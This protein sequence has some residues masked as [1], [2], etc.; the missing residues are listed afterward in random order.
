M[1]PSGARYALDKHENKTFKNPLTQVKVTQRIN[2]IA[3]LLQT[4]GGT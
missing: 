1:T 4:V 2:F 3:N